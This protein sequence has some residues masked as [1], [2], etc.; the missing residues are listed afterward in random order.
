[1]CGA[2]SW[3]VHGMIFLVMLPG[4]QWCDCG[5]EEG[6]FVVTVAVVGVVVVTVVVAGR[7]CSWSFAPS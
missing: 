7:T 2:G 1:M 6:L 4:S 5:L 3:K